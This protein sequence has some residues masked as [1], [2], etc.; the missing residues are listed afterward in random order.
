MKHG[1]QCYAN[2]LAILPFNLTLLYW[3]TKIGLF[4]KVGDE[5]IIFLNLILIYLTL[6]IFKLRQI[7]RGFKTY[8]T[9]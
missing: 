6:F 9:Y 2:P 7:F 5:N 8:L 4:F 3:Q 1:G